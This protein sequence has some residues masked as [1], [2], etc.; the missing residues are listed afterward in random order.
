MQQPETHQLRVFS[1]VTQT[2]ILL[3]WIIYSLTVGLLLMIPAN[4]YLSPLTGALWILLGI[5]FF[6]YGFTI[7]EFTARGHSIIPRMASDIFTVDARVYKLMLYLA[8]SASLLAATPARLSYIVEMFLA[9]VTPA[10]VTFI[11]FHYTAAQ[12]LNP[13]NVFR[14][15][16]NMGFTYN[17]LKFLGV[18]VLVCLMRI[19]I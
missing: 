19:L 17:A 15:I 2:E 13:L 7:I 9:V 11:A 10:I 8:I 3:V 18:W 1:F 14:F 12:A 6:Q 16:S 4:N 5:P